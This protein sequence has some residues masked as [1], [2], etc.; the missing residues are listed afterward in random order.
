MDKMDRLTLLVQSMEDEMHKF[1]VNVNFTKLK[2]HLLQLQGSE[3]EA[4]FNLVTEGEFVEV[5]CN[6]PR[7]Y[8]HSDAPVGKTNTAKTS[9]VTEGNKEIGPSYSMPMPPPNP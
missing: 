8:S 6:S 3:S 1:G 2:D 5:G 4:P 7:H 9:E